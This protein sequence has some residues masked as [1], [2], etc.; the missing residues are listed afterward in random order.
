MGEIDLN[1]F[2]NKQLKEWPLAAKNFADLSQVKTRRVYL[3]QNETITIQFN[4]KRITSSIA[5]TDSQS[6]SC[7]PC[8][9]CAKNR[10]LE[11][12]CIPFKS[13][14]EILINPFPIFPLH[15]TIA[16][17]NHKPQLIAN[18]LGDMLD[19]TEELKNYIVFYNGPKCGASA[20]DHFHF[21]AGK[22]GLLP[23]ESEETNIEKVTIFSDKDISVEASDNYLRKFIIIK[24]KDNEKIES[25]AKKIFTSMLTL[26][27]TIEEPMINL[28]AGKEKEIKKLYIFPRSAHRPKQFYANE[29]QKILFSPASVDFGGLLITP[30]KSDFAK[31]N[32]QLITDL[33]KQV[34]LSDNNWKSLLKYLRYNEF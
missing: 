28:L 6:L 2:I 13:D 18:R 27:K 23:I 21:Q 14:Y 34:T 1:S 26:N 12:L 5:K 22:K 15:L 32:K 29:P 7:R 17:K 25:C 33:L 20:P 8:L 30:R 3:T 31:L 24:S 11:Q 9:L 19:L 10:P 16:D 4:P